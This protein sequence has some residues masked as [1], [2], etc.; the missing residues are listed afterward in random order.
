MIVYIR[1]HAH[2][3]SCNTIPPFCR[4]WRQMGRAE[5]DIRYMPKILSCLRTRW[6]KARVDFLNTRPPTI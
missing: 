5:V 1:T 3:P 6:K 2:T 4:T